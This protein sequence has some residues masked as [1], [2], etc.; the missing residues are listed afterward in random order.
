V[1]APG[2]R[3][4][5]TRRRFR[6]LLRYVASRLGETRLGRFARATSLALAL[7]AIAWVVVLRVSDGAAAPVAAVP[8][9]VAKMGFWLV[10][11]PVA[12]AAAHARTLSDERDGADALV[13]M[14]G[15]DSGA[16]A[17]ARVAGAAL[18]AALGGLVPAIA[19]AVSSAGASP[20]ASALGERVLMLV[21]VC[22][23]SVVAGGVV[24]ALGALADLAAPRRGRWLLITATLVSW[25]ISDIAHDPRLSLTG[26]LGLVLRQMV[27]LFGLGKVGA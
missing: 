5:L 6:A 24:G 27:A 17:G 22:V 4:A 16:I 3:D 21:A 15:F 23:Y 9:R 2:P 18:I 26:L 25:A 19:A 13:R 12:L 7:A 10:A 8:L 1:P 11:V 20:S 14:R